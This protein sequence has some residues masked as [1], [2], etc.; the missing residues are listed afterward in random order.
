MGVAVTFLD[1]V[2][3]D[4]TR[5]EL[6]ELRDLFVLAYRRPAAAEQL[7]DAAGLVPGT[8]PLHANMRATWTELVRVLGDQGNL[9]AAV[10]LAAKDPS[11][12]GYWSRF[13]EMLG[14]SPPVAVPQPE[15]EV[16]DSWKGDDEARV[17][18]ERLMEQ[19]NRLIH[20]E[21]AAL[22][23]RKAGSVAKLS[24]RFGD[25]PG[26]ATGFLIQRNVILTNHHN[27]V[28]EQ[29]GDVT[30]IV[31]EF[32][33]RRDYG[34]KAGIVRRGRVDTI[35]GDPADDWAAITLEADVDRPPLKLGTPYGIGA[36]DA[37][38]IIQHP[39]GAFKQFALETLAVRYV[40]DRRV[41]YVADTQQG[42]SGSPVFN[43]HMDVIA[44]H[45]GEAETLVEIDGAETVVW[46]NEGI[47]IAQVI[48]G[49]AEH[50]IE[51]EAEA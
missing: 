16:L 42:S 41:Q 22:V 29:L 26:Y 40:D 10:Q 1:E 2:P 48:K 15:A 9:R 45:H 21:V 18:L 5:P 23:A 4:W 47:R 34:G 7:S 13:T 35:V 17:H 3:Q 31:A 12:S 38:I 30:S 11:A 39:L 20:V 46:R 19:R 33:Y 50:G 32:D 49:L 37:V 25:E 8:F 28:D 44:L 14:A 43:I 51:F 27:V 36:N 6:P 24:L